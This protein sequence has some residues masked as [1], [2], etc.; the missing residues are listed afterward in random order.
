M[1]KTLDKGSLFAVE[2][3]DLCT[4]PL[5][6]AAM[7]SVSDCIL[8]GSTFAIEIKVTVCLIEFNSKNLPHAFLML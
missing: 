7:D 1:S 8:P 5:R 2:M 6:C 3:P 4:I